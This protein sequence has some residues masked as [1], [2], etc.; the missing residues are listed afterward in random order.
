MVYY[1]RVKVVKDEEGIRPDC[2]PPFSVVQYLDDGTVIIK[3]NEPI[4]GL[5]PLTEDELNELV[6]NPIFKLIEVVGKVYGFRAKD[7]IVQ[8]GI[9]EDGIIC[10]RKE[11]YVEVPVAMDAEGNIIEKRKVKR[12]KLIRPPV[13]RMLAIRNNKL[14]VVEE[15]TEDKLNELEERKAELKRM[16]D[17]GRITEEEYNMEMAK[18]PRVEGGWLVYEHPD[19][20]VPVVG[21][22]TIKLKDIRMRWLG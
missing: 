4:E 19:T 2:E 8:V 15:A 18:L 1:Y 22:G 20:E 13:E 7:G 21:D 5:E 10:L 3:R 17:E 11:E 14:V 16:L 12:V 9:D 6:T